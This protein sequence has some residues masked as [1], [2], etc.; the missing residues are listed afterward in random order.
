MFRGPI[1]T[2]L[3]YK[4]WQYFPKGDPDQALKKMARA[5]AA[6]SFVG[7]RVD[8]SLGSVT[9][10]QDTTGTG[11][12]QVLQVVARKQG[13]GFRVDATFSVANGQIAAESR[14]RRDLCAIVRPHANLL[15]REVSCVF[16]GSLRSAA[17][18]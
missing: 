8:R 5:V 2:S 11:R 12:E 3:T 6:Q 18:Q 17:F 1:L 16:P 14:V 9:A 13:G 15:N 7:V 10:Y 4:S